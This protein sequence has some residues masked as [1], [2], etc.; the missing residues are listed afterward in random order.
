ML[1]LIAE[2]ARAGD[3][4]MENRT[5]QTFGH[6]QL[7][8][9]LGDRFFSQLYLGQ[10]LQDSEPVLIRVLDLFPPH[11]DDEAH[12]LVEMRQ[13]TR[14]HHPHLLPIRD[15]GVQ[16]HIPFLVMDY[17][18]DCTLHDYL[19]EHPALVAI[20]SPINSLAAT[21]QELHEQQVIHR[22]LH[23]DEVWMANDHP[24]LSEP[25]TTFERSLRSREELIDYVI[26]NEVMERECSYLAPEQLAGQQCDCSTSDQYALALMIYEWICGE[27]PFKGDWLRATLQRLDALPPP[28]REKAPMFPREVEAVVMRGL[29]KDPQKR[30]ASLQAFDTALEQAVLNEPDDGSFIS[31]T[32]G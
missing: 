8:R 9:L 11:A 1:R 26:P 32:P 31:D 15:G 27:Y 23:P 21:L 13:F 20:V 28:S 5:G 17:P 2:L 18:P 12:F 10:H 19:A 14:L 30:F 29:E 25:S 24:M 4:P 7:I 16:D 6:Y 3:S 22:P